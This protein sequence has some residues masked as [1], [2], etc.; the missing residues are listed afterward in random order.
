[1]VPLH[2]DPCLVCEMGKSKG[3]VREIDLSIAI[4]AADVVL[5]VR[6][7]SGHLVNASTTIRK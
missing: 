6:I 3:N 5:R 1:M 4:V 7:T 2:E